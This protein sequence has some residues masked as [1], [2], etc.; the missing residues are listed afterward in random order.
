MFLINSPIE[1]VK[2]HTDQLEE[3]NCLLLKRE[4][5]NN[6][7]DFMDLYVAHSLD[8]QNWPKDKPIRILDIGCPILESM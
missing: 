6:V 4:K 2:Q 3:C 1:F 5:T 8:E 7:R